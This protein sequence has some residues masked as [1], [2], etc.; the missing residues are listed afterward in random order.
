L[1][2]LAPAESALLSQPSETRILSISLTVSN[3]F[4]KNTELF[5]ETLSGEH[6]LIKIRTL[7]CFT[8]FREGSY[9]RRLLACL[10]PLSLQSQLTHSR[11]TLARHRLTGKRL[12]KVIKA[13]PSLPPGFL[14][15]RTNLP[16]Q[17][18]NTQP[19]RIFEGH[20]SYLSSYTI[21]SVDIA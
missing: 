7:Y 21:P 20:C 14:K 8:L 11:P 19:E 9:F 17:P 12:V 10:L 13:L 3:V 4:P 6:L 15:Q 2:R 18:V 16:G 1:L 5:S